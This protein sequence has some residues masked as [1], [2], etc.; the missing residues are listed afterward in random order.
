M[1][2]AIAALFL[3]GPLALAQVET[4]E[5]RVSVVDDR[6]E[7]V[8]ASILVRA[9]GSEQFQYA[10]VSV[11]GGSHVITLRSGVYDIEITSR[12]RRETI[13]AIQLERNQIRTLPPVELYSVGICLCS[14]LRVLQYYFQ[15]LNSGGPATGAIT[16]H[17]FNGGGQPVGGATVFL[18]APGLGRIATT[19]TDVGG[20]F[21]MRGIPA[22]RNYWIRTSHAEYLDDEFTDLN[23]QPGF[24][25]VYEPIYL[26]SCHPG[27]CF[28]SLRT[29]RDLRG[30]E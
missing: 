7:P 27:L 12:F 20:S 19:A 8:A 29:I 18:Y 1:R 9:T 23:V 5:L 11:A 15:P 6:R 14:S 30:C 10:P 22:R 21:T 3:S 17:I 24:D 26:E 4:G 2:W 13:R 25:T 28:P 16:S